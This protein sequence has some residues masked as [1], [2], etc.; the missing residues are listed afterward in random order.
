VTIFI[1]LVL[2]SL[3]PA[4]A[5]ASP[6]LK[7]EFRSSFYTHYVEGKCGQNVK[8]LLERART[9]G[10]DLRGARVVVIRNKGYMLSVTHR[11]NSGKEKL[12]APKYGIRFAPGIRNF[13]FHVALEKDGE[14]YDYDFANEPLILPAKE[15]IRRMFWE[16]PADT[17]YTGLEDLKYRRDYRITFSSAEDYVNDREPAHEA[18]YDLSDFYDSL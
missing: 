12:A 9:S 11:R 8:N 15:Y 5:F 14:I 1:A 16:E 3:L 13:Y 2:T 6:E 4:Q 7:D 17:K 10:A 18:E